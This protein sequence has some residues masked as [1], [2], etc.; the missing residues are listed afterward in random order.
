MVSGSS[1]FFNAHQIEV[2]GT[3]LT[4]QLDAT[5]AFAEFS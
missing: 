4:L 2:N 1:A 5:I 3:Q